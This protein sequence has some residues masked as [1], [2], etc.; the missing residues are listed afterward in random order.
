[1]IRA[2]LGDR[3]GRIGHNVV[4]IVNA[5][6]SGNKRSGIKAG[7]MDVYRQYDDGREEVRNLAISS[8]GGYFLYDTKPGS[9][10]KPWIDCKA[11]REPHTSS[12][13]VF[14]NLVA[15]E[16]A[17]I[18][19]RHPGFRWMLDKILAKRPGVQVAEVI[20]YIRAWVRW[21]ECE[22]LYN[23]EYY[24]LC[25]SESFAMA[26]YRKQCEIMQYL[27]Q[28]P[29]IK[30]PGFGEILTLMKYGMS[31]DDYY[32]TKRYHIGADL[33]KYLH[34]QLRNGTVF[35]EDYSL[36]A[37]YGVY[38]DY[39]EMVDSNGHD[40]KQDYWKYPSDLRE[41]HDKV[42][43]EAANIKAATLKKRQKKYTAAVKKFIGKTVEDGNIR[44]FVPESIEEISLQA[45]V[46]HQCLV[47]ADYIG[48]VIDRKCLLVFIKRGN[49]PIATAEVLPSGKIGQF[50]GDERD[51]NNCE[52]GET[53]KRAIDVW[54]TT[55]K[56]K[57]RKAKEAA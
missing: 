31:Q 55:F 37:L 42:M 15:T 41:A 16:Y 21:P 47:T 12:Y 40:K 29:E 33:L 17:Q 54:M 48:K 3:I 26:S 52:P 10:G 45:S 9:W 38:K 49:T 35:K 5:S 50:Y 6:W 13:M 57:I 46:L 7:N 22:R 44:V 14:T 51:R 56:P 8:M 23:G 25:L 34:A 32:M 30:D 4:R 2:I 24:R 36:E 18:V 19:D 28:H 53:E 39:I 43:R 11:L 1:M 27:K 20:E